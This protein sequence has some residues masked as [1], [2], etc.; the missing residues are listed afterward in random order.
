[1]LPAAFKF[2]P[3]STLQPFAYTMPV[4]AVILGWIV[5]DHIP[6]VMTLV[7]GGI[8]ISSGLFAIW[9]ERV[10]ENVEQ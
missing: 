2:A 3:A 1:M 7:G 5:F 9:R 6:D 10:A 8:I 4:W